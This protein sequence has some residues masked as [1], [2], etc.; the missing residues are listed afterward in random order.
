M[1]DLKALLLGG[2]IGL[3]SAIIGAVVDYRILK[4]KSESENGRLPGCIFFIS[5]FL[6]LLGVFVI[7][8]SS[9]L[10]SFAQAIT[11]GMGVVAGFFLGFLIMM[12]AWFIVRRNKS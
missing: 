11:A 6:G 1:F 2:G 5:G 7:L 4:Q 8:I 12:F 9:M 3:S 10:D